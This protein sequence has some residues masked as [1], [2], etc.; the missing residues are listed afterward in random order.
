MIEDIEKTQSLES[1]IICLTGGRCLS[2]NFII[3][4]PTNK[5]EE[6]TKWSIERVSTQVF[7]LSR[8]SK[9]VKTTSEDA[10]AVSQ[11][12]PIAC[13]ADL[14]H[15]TS[16]AIKQLAVGLETVELQQRGTIGAVYF[17]K[18]RNKTR[19][20]I[21]KKLLGVKPSKKRPRVPLFK[22]V[23]M[24]T[25]QELYTHIDVSQLTADFCGTIRYNHVS[26]LHLYNVVIKC[27]EG[28]QDLLTKLPSVRDKIDLLQE[29]E[30]DGLTSS[31]AQQLL[32]DLIERFHMI[33]SE[34][35]LPLYL[36]QCKQTL[37]LLDHPSSDS[38]L[39]LV[40]PELVSGLKAHLRGT[41][42]ELDQWGTD[43]ED[44]WRVT[45]NR[46]TVL[47]QFYRHKERAKEIERKIC[48]HFHPLLREH[49]IVGKTL[50]QAE[51]HRAHFTT[52]LYDPAKEL[53]SQ[54][55]EI[56]EA[57]QRLK[58]DVAS[59][60]ASNFCRRGSTGTH[61]GVVF[62][63]QDI[64]D[65]SKCLTTSIQPFTTQLQQLQQLYVSIHIFHLLFEK[66]LI[67]YKKVLK[68]IPESLL[69]RCSTE[70]G[71][72]ASDVL[73][74]VSHQTRERLVYM[75]TEW[76]G[77]VRVFLSR[78]P[79]PRQEHIDRIDE[80]IPQHVDRKLRCQARSLA[81]RLQLLQ[82]VLTSTRLPLKVVTAVL[83]WRAELFGL[84]Q[85]DK[86]SGA[87]HTPTPGKDLANPG[88]ST[89][90]DTLGHDR[91]TARDQQKPNGNRPPEKPPRAKKFSSFDHEAPSKSN[92]HARASVVGSVSHEVIK[93][94]EKSPVRRNS[95]VMPRSK[96]VDFNFNSSSTDGSVFDYD[97]A[98]AQAETET[99]TVKIKPM[100]RK[101]RTSVKESKVRSQD[102]GQKVMHKDGGLSG[103][104]KGD[105]E[106]PF[107][108][109]QKSHRNEQGG[110]ELK[111]GFLDHRSEKKKQK[112]RSEPEPH[113][114]TSVDHKHAVIHAQYQKQQEKK[115]PT[116]LEESPHVPSSDERF[117]RTT[118]TPKQLNANKTPSFKFSSADLLET[119]GQF[120]FDEEDESGIDLAQTTDPYDKVINR[121]KEISS[122]DLTNIEKLKQ[123]SELLSRSSVKQDARDK[124]LAST[125]RA[126]KMS[127]STMDLRQAGQ[128]NDGNGNRTLSETDS[129]NIN[130]STSQSVRPLEAVQRMKKNLAK[131]ME[132]LNISSYPDTNN[133][134]SYHH[135][136]PAMVDNHKTVRYVSELKILPVYRKSD[137]VSKQEVDKR[138]DSPSHSAPDDESS[139]SRMKDNLDARS[140]SDV[141]SFS[142]GA[143][144]SLSSKD[145]TPPSKQI[146]SSYFDIL[147]STKDYEF[148][149]FLT[150]RFIPDDSDVDLSPADTVPHH[151]NRRLSLTR[152]T[153]INV[154]PS[155]NFISPS[156]LRPASSM[157]DLSNRRHPEII[158]DLNVGLEQD[159]QALEDLEVLQTIDEDS[160]SKENSKYALK[161]PKRRSNDYNGETLKDGLWDDGVT[162]GKKGSQDVKAIPAVRVNH[163]S[164]HWS[165]FEG[166]KETARPYLS[167]ADINFDRLTR[168][169][170]HEH[171]SQEE[172]AESLRK[173]QKILEEEEKR[174][175][176]IHHLSDPS[177][178]EDEVDDLLRAA[179]RL[180][181]TTSIDNGYGSW[182]S[183]LMRSTSS[184]GAIADR[185]WRKLSCSSADSSAKSPGNAK[186]NKSKKITDD[187]EDNHEACDTVYEL[188]VFEKPLTGADLY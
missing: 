106:S 1:G 170:D 54:A 90:Q 84:G 115:K 167:T 127:H 47:I 160:L 52:T 136:S 2:G 164:T 69:Q 61:S 86:A 131:S 184:E 112:G 133:S 44:A 39:S 182:P 48:K 149:K 101:S 95:K 145:P 173:T 24:K 140:W 13:L 143:S 157:I 88:P 42:T 138:D 124:S 83:A 19:S 165:S 92:S 73:Q 30:T 172:V 148:S 180:S 177:V 22:V 60:P 139:L 110:E 65:I 96:S 132:E 130:Q 176:Q 168:E 66:A 77:A 23:L 34:S 50:S 134:Q 81:L 142:Q 118:F 161:T 181:H 175:L 43:L 153:N 5:L 62:C 56:L 58:N 26:W 99:A 158:F 21:L 97:K 8:I 147:S 29:Y 11:I 144:P 151:G 10:T 171:Q 188:P 150:P 187:D 12:L 111:H 46:L 109:V 100:P 102:E 116:P 108:D 114:S 154:Y 105:L 17:L 18:P 51:L 85:H 38:H 155:R 91:F 113:N 159:Y 53:L 163:L 152:P 70:F 103:N 6:L 107:H 186:A 49:P 162:S 16:L 156:F 87:H 135:Q 174:R 37:F 183:K 117:I 3:T 79:P 78:H 121:I 129:A 123:V 45:E 93:G 67:W 120:N 14:R 71:H 119:T 179:E 75:P 126:S 178:E 137:K 104:K 20:H 166:Q 94:S 141:E 15:A 169:A 35:S 25:V 68:F 40:H 82:R 98:L 36:T 74:D 55:T 63:D 72:S 185:D 64:S 128:D 7:H 146:P 125:N 31:Q 33:V 122:S 76:L 9:Y 27:I 32:A 41:Y 28:C 89:N 4:I 80:S 57:V 59:Q